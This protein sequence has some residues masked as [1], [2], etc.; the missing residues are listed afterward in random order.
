MKKT[1]AQWVLTL[2]ALLAGAGCTKTVLVPVSSCPAPPQIQ[3]PYLMVDNLPP[4]TTRRNKLQAIKM[5]LGTLRKE[6]EA[7]I[8]I[9]DGYRKAPTEPLPK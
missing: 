1:I 8:V 3:M 7:C 6:L 4:Q 2:I 5:D 9:V